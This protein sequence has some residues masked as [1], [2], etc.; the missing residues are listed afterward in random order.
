M[1]VRVCAC[2]ALYLT[3]CEFNLIE[4][5]M[6]TNI[7]SRKAF[8]HQI[9]ASRNYKLDFGVAEGTHRPTDETTGF[10]SQAISRLTHK[11]NTHT[12]L[13]T[14]HTQRETHTR[15]HPHSHSLTHS[16]TLTHT[17]T[18]HTQHTTHTE[19]KTRSHTPLAHTLMHT[20][21]HTTHTPIT[22][23]HHVQR[24]THSHT[25][26]TEKHTLTHT[27]TH[28]PPIQPHAHCSVWFF[29]SQSFP[30]EAFSR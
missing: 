24:N 27:H 19:S 26:H 23:T 2:L 8:W 12:H 22:R 11:H 30:S 16:H 21:T 15:T 1:C 18:P 4:T 17:H 5:R 3:S 14:H 9:F 7:E 20:R 25:T 13:N 29:I 28:T 10:H 6:S